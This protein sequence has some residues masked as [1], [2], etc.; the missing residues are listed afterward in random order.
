MGWELLFVNSLKSLPLIVLLYFTIRQYIRERKYQ[1]EYAF[2]SSIAL[3]IRAYGELAGSKKE[4]LIS[5]AVENIYT[6][7]TMM[8]DT[9]PLFGLKSDHLAELLKEIKDIKDKMVK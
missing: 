9:T 2:R 3:T 5:K 1:E 4:E 6:M 7:P 8:K